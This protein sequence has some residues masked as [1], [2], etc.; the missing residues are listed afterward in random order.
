MVS[1]RLSVTIWTAR[2]AWWSVSWLWPSDTNASMPWVSASSPVAALSH[3]GIVVSSR[4]SMTV[5]SG[6]R[7][8]PR[9]VILGAARGVGDDA[10]LR[11]VGAG[12]RR[13]RHH[14]RRRDRQPGLVHAFVVE[15]VA[16]VGGQD[17][18][19]FAASITDPR[20][21]P[22]ARR[23]RARRTSGSRRRSRGP[24]GWAS[25]RSTAGVDALMPQVTEH[26][27]DPARLDQPRVGDQHAAAARPGAPR[28]APLRPSSRYRTRSPARE[29]SAAG[30]A[31]RRRR[32]VRIRVSAPASPSHTAIALC[33]S[34]ATASPRP[35][36]RAS[37]CDPDNIPGPARRR[38]LIPRHPYPPESNMRS[39]AESLRIRL[40]QEAHLPTTSPASS[41]AARSSP[42]R[43][44]TTRTRSQNSA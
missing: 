40:A 14:D 34:F 18:H 1:S 23:S 37:E 8:R 3:S 27:V 22:P 32:R 44:R 16:A 36:R 17:R 38:R 20:R 42:L 9:I 6:T 11:Y 29:T 7:A 39:P 13:R 19:P 41:C 43:S 5:M 4:G 12:A 25:A 26:L 30:R 15:D 33:S 2:S 35:P 21:P 31:G 10:E 28:R 24:W